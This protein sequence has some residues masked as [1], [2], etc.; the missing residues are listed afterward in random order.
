MLLLSARE[1]TIRSL[2]QRLA[3]EPTSES[4]WLLLLRHSMSNIGP[5]SKN[6]DRARAEISVSILDRALSAHQA[7]ARSPLLRLKYLKAGE[8]IWDIPKMK[9]EWGK[10]L[11]VIP[12]ANMYVEWLDWI[13]RS[14]PDFNA[15]VDA[16]TET[17]NL[18][19]GIAAG[20]DADLAKLRVL[21][22][23]ATFF[24]QAGK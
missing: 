14:T 5:S 1:E 7:N 10:T 2:E 18:V 24:R 22:R 12:T 15:V 20:D 21:W 3:N 9:E 23:I 4:T 17:T 13:M 6:A 19:S 16:A 11:K 8:V